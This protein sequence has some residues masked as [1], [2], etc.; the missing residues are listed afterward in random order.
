MFRKTLANNISQRDDFRFRGS[1]V[2]RIEAFSDAVF[3]FAV[4]LLIVSLEVPRS[5]EEL[6]NTM[7]GFVA[8]S[9]T[10]LLLM[11]IWY[12][13]NIFFRRYGLDDLTTIILNCALIFLVLFYVYPLKFLFSLLFNNANDS[14]SMTGTDSQ[15]LMLIY[16]S[17]YICI[18]LLFLLMHIHAFR[19]KIELKLTP[20]EIFDTH[21]KIYKNTILVSIGV[22]SILFALLL[23]P[24]R[25]GLAGFVYFLIGPAFSL[26]FRYRGAKKIKLYNADAEKN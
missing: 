17:G 10:F 6:M 16:G 23:K 18:Y 25:S 5:F 11:L 19:K 9:V 21:T 24:E 26:F 13:Q 8:F 2:K 1:E 22:I 20:S 7:R 15:K 3:A 14:L 4:T 12:E